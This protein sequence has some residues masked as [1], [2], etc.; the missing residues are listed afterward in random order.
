MKNALINPALGKFESHSKSNLKTRTVFTYL[1][2]RSWLDETGA[3][4]DE[5]IVQKWTDVWNHVWCMDWCI[6]CC[7]DW[8]SLCGLTECVQGDDNGFTSCTCK[9]RCTKSPPPAPWRGGERGGG[10]V[11]TPSLP[12]MVAPFQFH[13]CRFYTKPICYHASHPLMALMAMLVD[14]SCCCKV[15]KLFLLVAVVVNQC[16]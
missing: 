13:T 9:T 15:V 3:L 1:D 11:Y 16:K 14:F 8:R 6:D 7:P 5:Q 4:S 12:V 2:P 10:C